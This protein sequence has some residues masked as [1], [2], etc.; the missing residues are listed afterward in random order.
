MLQKAI[1]EFVQQQKSQLPDT[2]HRS[3]VTAADDV[4]LEWYVS[5]LAR[6]HINSFRSATPYLQSWLTTAC[7]HHSVDRSRPIAYHMCLLA[8]AR[9]GGCLFCECAGI[10][11][12]VT[13][14][15]QLRGKNSRSCQKT[16]Q[17][18]S[19]AFYLI[20]HLSAAS[21]MEPC[22]TG[23]A[24]L[25]VLDLRGMLPCTQWLSPVLSGLLL[26]GRWGDDDW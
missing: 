18:F 5:M 4:S 17:L 24:V 26:Q 22:H 6:L 7:L 12:S 16:L 2:V 19:T 8:P 20:M 25:Y 9:L 21:Y 3:L 11:H 10:R 13:V 1:Q 14:R 15:W 23:R